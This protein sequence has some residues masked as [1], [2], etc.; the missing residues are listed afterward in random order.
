[1]EVNIKEQLELE[2]RDELFTDITHEK[3]LELMSIHKVLVFRYIKKQ[4]MELYLKTRLVRFY[5]SWITESRIERVYFL[6]IQ[7]FMSDA[8][9][10][11]LKQ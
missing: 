3:L 11:K 5:E 7:K 4:N 1:M 8:L 2:A 10:G 9:D 6:P